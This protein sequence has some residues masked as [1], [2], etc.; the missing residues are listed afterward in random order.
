MNSKSHEKSKTVRYP[1]LGEISLTK[2]RS[3]IFSRPSFHSD[4]IPHNYESDMDSGLTRSIDTGN[5]LKI[6]L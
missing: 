1:S 2:E 3:V 6:Y 4:P 5:K